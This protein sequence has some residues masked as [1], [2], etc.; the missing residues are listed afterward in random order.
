MA[1]VSRRRIVCWP[2][3]H[4][5]PELSTVTVRETVEREPQ[6]P[7]GCLNTLDMEVLAPPEIGPV[8]FCM[9][10]RSQKSLECVRNAEYMLHPG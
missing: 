2:G 5:Y 8:I 9:E 4:K 7:V 6:I 10:W 1:C 3:Y